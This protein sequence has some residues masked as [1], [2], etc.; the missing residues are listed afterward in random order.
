MHTGLGI[1]LVIAKTLGK[2]FY[3]RFGGIVCRVAG[4]VGDALF[5]AGY[6]DGGGCRGGEEGQ[7][8]GKTVG[9]AEEVSGE[10]LEVGESM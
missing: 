4:R 2:G 9:Y 6:D 5:G 10:D 8:S 7:E 1:A 3:S